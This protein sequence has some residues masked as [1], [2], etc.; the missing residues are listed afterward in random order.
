[1]ARLPGYEDQRSISTGSEFMRARE[2][3]DRTSR[4]VQDLASTIGNLGGELAKIDARLEDKARRDQER[5]ERLEAERDVLLT[6]TEARIRLQQAKDNISESGKG[7]YDSFMPQYDQLWQDRLKNTP[8]RLRPEMENKYFRDRE[9]MAVRVS[10]IEHSQRNQF[11]VKVADEKAKSLSSGIAAGVIP[12]ETAASEVTSFVKSL[13]L[14]PNAARALERQ[15]GMSVDAAQVQ[16]SIALNPDGALRDLKQYTPGTPRSANP[17]VQVSIEAAERNGIPINVMLPIIKGE[18][19][20][21]PNADASKRI[22]PVT[23]KPVGT[24][25]GLGQLT[26]ATWRESGLPKSTDPVIQAEATARI[27]GKRIATLQANGIEATPQNVWGSHFVGPAAYM[28]MLRA[29]PNTPL[30]DVLLPKYG[31]NL[32]KQ[33][34]T[35]NGTLLQDGATVGQTL[36]KINAY[37]DRNVEGV[38][39]LVTS[40]AGID[41][42]Q[43]VTVGG[44]PLKYMTGEDAMRYVGKAQEAVAQARDAEMK[45]W[46]K[47]QL[48]DGLLNPFTSGDRKAMDKLAATTGVNVA[49]NNG[50]ANAYGV[51]KAHVLQH[52][53]LPKP[54]AEEA[55]LAI[56]SPD[57]TKRALG[58][59]LLSTVELQQP[60]GGLRQSGIQP[61]ITKRVER[62][63]ALRTQLNMEPRQAMALVEREFSPDYAD[64][65]RKDKER[66]DNIVRRQSNSA[67]ESFFK[68][69]TGWWPFNGTDY[70]TDATKRAMLAT[71]QDRVRYHLDD[72]AGETSAVAMAKN[73]MSRA[74]GVD[75]TFG[76]QRLMHWPPSKILPTGADGTHKWVA[77]SVTSFVNDSLAAN[78]FKFK[79]QPK[80]VY[81]IGTTETARAVMAGQAPYYDV[82]YR[83]NRG[84]IQM[85]PGGYRVDPEEYQQKL[86]QQRLEAP[87]EKPRAD[88]GAVRRQEQEMYAPREG[89]KRRSTFPNYLRPPPSLDRPPA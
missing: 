63:V 21:D 27:L 81:L 42:K 88:V 67:I 64:K 15:L 59:D 34:V 40:D 13:E 54:Y 76:A 32:Y 2:P 8:E 29:D 11:I 73:E 69:D 18:S 53:Y 49:M 44:T 66:V 51:A 80:D 14:P 47:Q 17:N 41:P 3:R 5:V 89:D 50:D 57:P 77:D 56:L 74:Y 23:G 68:S 45:A 61:D 6:D 37:V 39:A 82:A 55:E 85:L 30:R 83:D 75:N 36:A 48:D 62:F 60:M 86:I 72:G 7:F 71:F 78:N 35:G 79:V 16:R 12:H 52:K 33:A 9:Q 84:V 58:Y 25:Y 19:N 24:A 20:F 46:Q 31:E 10:A 4:A 70:G 26:D 43:T 28:A 87:A 22:N 38:K 1:M 65:V